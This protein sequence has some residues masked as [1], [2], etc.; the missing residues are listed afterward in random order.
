MSKAYGTVPVIEGEAVGEAV[1]VAGMRNKQGHSCCGG[2][3]DVRRASI[4]LD[5]MSLVSLVINVFALSAV[6][7]SSIFDDDEVKQ[8]LSE[9]MPSAG[10]MIA[11]FVFE[12]VL[13]GITVW[14][15]V[16]FSAPKVMVGLVVYSIG[17][18]TSMF[19]LNLVGVVVNVFFAYPHY[20]L[21]KEIKDGIMSK[22]NYYNEEQSC[23]CV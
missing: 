12:I 17:V 15:A 4:V 3:C 18:L 9:G 11:I 6:S 13:L 22:D 19:S 20:F 8:K 10:V 1:G 7:T 2:C 5:I 23:C 14:G 21:Y 16:S